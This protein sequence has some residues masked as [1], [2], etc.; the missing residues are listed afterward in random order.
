MGKLMM[1]KKYKHIDSILK[2][3]VFEFE[4]KAI[5][6]CKII[7]IIEYVKLFNHNDLNI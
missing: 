2:N 4:M 3:Y 7:Y 6:L 5:I 1:R